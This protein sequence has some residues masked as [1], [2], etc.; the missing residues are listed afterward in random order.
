MSCIC[1]KRISFPT[2][3]FATSQH[4]S[5]PTIDIV[6]TL[7][8]D[9]SSDQTFQPKE[10]FYTL[11]MRDSN[12]QKSE[13]SNK[14]IDMIQSVSPQWDGVLSCLED[15]KE[16]VR[17]CANTRSNT[18]F[19]LPAS[20]ESYAKQMVIREWKELEI[21][22]MFELSQALE[23]N[24]EQAKMLWHTASSLLEDMKGVLAPCTTKHA[25]SVA[26]HT[27]CTKQTKEKL[28]NDIDR[29]EEEIHKQ[30]RLAEFREAAEAPYA[31]LLCQAAS[32]IGVCG[33]RLD[34]YNGATLQLAYEH[35]IAGI[36]SIFIYDMAHGRW[37]ARYLSDAFISSPE[38]LPASHPAAK[39]HESVAMACFAD[40][41]GLLQRV[42]D[43]EMS[44]AVLTLSMWLA[45]LDTATQE[46]VDLSGMRS[47]SIDW[48]RLSISVDGETTLAILYDESVC[49]NFQPASG[50]VV[51]GGKET[52]LD[53]I[54]TLASLVKCAVK[55]S[56]K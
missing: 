15:L 47:I 5:S 29:L 28:E 24:T 53:M 12:K 44:D 42:R 52:R 26:N 32:H 4:S 17:F 36:E 21:E 11:A 30:Q 55:S 33:F 13:K 14:L 50:V 38:L 27:T 7:L 22:F 48:P 1:W 51:Q 8:K 56:T 23:R 31:A 19:R 20:Q 6:Q 37:S 39:F 16:Q 10:I 40:K 43:M 45:G 34:D 46:L 3:W 49:K 35:P 9:P 25:T 2:P 54:G 41:N 18:K